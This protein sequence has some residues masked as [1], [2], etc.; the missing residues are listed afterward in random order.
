MSLG[1]ATMVGSTVGAGA[2][3]AA[4]FIV[5]SGR[6]VRVRATYPDAELPGRSHEVSGLVLDR[7]LAEGGPEGW[8]GLPAA[9][10]RGA[11]L[12][13]L[14]GRTRVAAFR[15]GWIVLDLRTRRTEVVLDEPVA[16]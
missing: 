14:P 10:R 11:V 8:L 6:R 12:A 13:A 1:L 16:A 9:P 3:I 5:A 2:V 7:Y 4:G 15:H